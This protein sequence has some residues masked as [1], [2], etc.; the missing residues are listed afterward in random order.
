MNSQ[1][2]NQQLTVYVNAGVIPFEGNFVLERKVVIKVGIYPVHR[3]EEFVGLLVVVVALRA[4][5]QPVL[6]NRYQMLD[7]LISLEQFLECL[8]LVL[9][10]DDGVH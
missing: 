6:R 2:S 5:A 1:I 7:L 10:Y 9:C 8:S 4:A 3:C